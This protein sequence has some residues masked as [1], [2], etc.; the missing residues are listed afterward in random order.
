VSGAVDARLADARVG[1]FETRGG[2][3]HVARRGFLEQAHSFFTARDQHRA[4]PKMREQCAT[5]LFQ[6]FFIGQRT[7]YKQARFLGVAD[8]RF[9]ASISIKARSLGPTNTG[10]RRGGRRLALDRQIRR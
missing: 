5:R 8:D 1:N 6:R 7:R 4:A 2:N 9:R 10:L 3:I